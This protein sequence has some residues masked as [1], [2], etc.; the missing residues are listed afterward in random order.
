MKFID[1]K[2]IAFIFFVISWFSISAQVGVEYIWGGSN[3]TGTEYD[4]STFN[5]VGTCKSPYFKVG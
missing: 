4:N 5:G 3:S 2:K 1:I